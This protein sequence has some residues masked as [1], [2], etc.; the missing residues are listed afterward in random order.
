MAGEREYESPLHVESELLQ[1]R[2]AHALQTLRQG[3]GLVS[4]ALPKP[5]L[6]STEPLLRLREGGYWKVESQLKPPP[7][8]S[9]EQFGMIGR[10]DDDDMARQ[11]VDLQEERADDPLDL[12]CFVNV[13]AF[14]ADRV[15]LVEE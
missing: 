3:G 6:E 15:E 10:G 9:V 4:Q 2:E 14:L 1:F 5:F 12:P 11:L 7:N 8:R 13:A